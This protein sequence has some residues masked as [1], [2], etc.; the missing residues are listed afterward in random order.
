VGVWQ[1]WL[2]QPQSVF[3]RRALFQVHLW[4]GLA[5]GLYVVVVSLSGSVLVYRNELYRAFSPQPVIVA[6]SGPPMPLDD[7]KDVARRLYPGFEVTQAQE[8]KTPNHAIEIAMER[9][10]EVRRRLLHPF[11]G[12]D[13]GNPLPLGFRLAVW[14]LDLHDNL[15][16]GET[17]RAVNG[18][19]A[20]L[21][22]ALSLTG[23]VIWWPGIRSWR[24]S[25][26]IDVRANSRRMTW[27]LHSALGFWFF[28]F[29]LMWGVT[30]A[31]LSFPESFAAVFDRIQP[32]DESSLEERAV[33][34]IQYWLA[35]LHF[36]R[37]GGRGIP[38]CGR[39]CN[40]TTKVIWAVIGLVPVVMF[41]T[42]GLMWWNRVVRPARQRMGSV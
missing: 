34:R 12:E 11:T 37:L 23:A 20:L 4:T 25:L 40:S 42:G 30:G 10:D 13:L 32:L 5:V 36:G 24:R 3:L 27:S 35:Y 2:T 19:G 15:L 29:V 9:G 38:G 28:A 6:G 17:G 21:L 7:L 39:L 1:R 33:D 16:S 22:L 18:V 41:V 31:Y 8:G 14:L 26:V